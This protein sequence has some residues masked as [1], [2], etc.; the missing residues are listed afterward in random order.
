MKKQL[1]FLYTLYIKFTQLKSAKNILG[2]SSHPKTN[3][4]LLSSKDKDRYMYD[5][6]IGERNMVCSKSS[7]TKIGS[8]VWQQCERDRLRVKEARTM[9]RLTAG[10]PSV[11]DSQ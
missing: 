10:A 4:T 2:T 1:R 7:L 8:F 3:N 6:N 5:L 11:A 9:A